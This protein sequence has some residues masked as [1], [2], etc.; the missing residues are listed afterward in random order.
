MTG[1]TIPDTLVDLLTTNVLARIATVRPD[2]AP[3]IANSWIDYDGTHIMTS[4][5]GGSRKAANIRKNPYV[6]I[7]VVDPTDPWRYLLVRGHVVEIRPDTDLSFIDKLSRRYMGADY[8][9]RDTDRD[10]FVIE[11]DYVRALGA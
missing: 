10:I 4:S 5:S 8:G 3:A 7:S 1:S 11:I 2:G 6:A 9:T